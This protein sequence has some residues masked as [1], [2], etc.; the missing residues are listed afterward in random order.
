MH[1]LPNPA[2]R[3][4]DWVR[5]DAEVE[6]RTR[7]WSIAIL[8]LLAVAAAPSV[9]ARQTPAVDSLRVVAKL[10]GVDSIND[11]L[12]RYGVA[13]ADLGHTFVYDG[14]LYMV[15]GDTFG[16]AG[17][18]W[19]S[20]TLAVIDDDDPSDGLTFD[21]MIEDAPGHAKEVLSSKKFEHDEITVIPTY[22]IAIG[23][24]LF[25]HY[26]S[27]HEW[28]APGHW[29]LNASGI[30][31]SDDGGQTWVKDPGATWAGDSNFGQAAI[32]AVGEDVYFFGIPGGRYGGVHL[33]RVAR[34]HV[35]D[36]EEYAYWDGR[37]W[38]TD[39]EATAQ[40]VVPAPV[41]E[42]SVRW[43]SY[44]RKWLMM[45]LDESKYA[46]VLRTADCLTG[47]WSDE[48]TIA[49]GTDY[50]QLY[51]P[52]LLPKWNDGPDV[53]FTLSQFGPYSV[54]LMRTELEGVAPSLEA[55]ECVSPG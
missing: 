12:D 17:G 2:D 32:V 14:E 10:I 39:G 50:P 13:G 21:R 36:K 8:A 31:Y 24:R 1:D 51:A 18:D 29:N 41:G 6:M 33:A 40:T 47:R 44:Y 52:Y 42:L 54:F 19:R 53:Y 9:Q 49:T 5:A 37:S 55:P 7:L 35:L 28:G 3:S 4:A 23:D 46:V 45:Y 15:F 27:V 26:M 20:N 11:T 22:G 16:I 34:E 25:L 38:V 43:N 30:A 48:Q